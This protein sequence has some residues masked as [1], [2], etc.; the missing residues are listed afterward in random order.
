[1]KYLY[2]T[3]KVCAVISALFVAFLMAG[4][5]AGIFQGSYVLSLDAINYAAIFWVL[6]KLAS[7]GGKK[8]AEHLE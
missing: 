2:L 7:W 1:M 4:A 5:V 6:M 8:C 3:Y